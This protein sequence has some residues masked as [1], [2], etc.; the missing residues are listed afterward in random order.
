L[1]IPDSLFNTQ[2]YEELL[3]FVLSEVKYPEE[4]LLKSYDLF[5][6]NKIDQSYIQFNDGRTIERIST[7]LV[8]NG[9]LE[10]TVLSF[11]D[12]TEKVEAEKALIKAKIHA[13]EA[14]RTKSEFLATMSHELR[15]PLNS[16]IG[17]S[18]ILRAQLFGLLNERQLKYL[19]NISISGNHLLNLI[20]D[21]LDI[22]RIESGDVSLYYETMS[23]KELFEDVRNIAIPL[24]SSKNIF[25]EF[26]AKPADLKIYADKIKVKQILHNL[27][28]NALK[29]TPNNGHV[30]VWAKMS[31]DTIEISVKDNGIG[32]PEDKQKIIFEPFKQLDSSLSRNYSGT[33]LGLMIVKK[34]IEMHGGEIRVESELTKGSKFTIILPIKK[35]KE[36]KKER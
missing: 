24:A 25:L 33:G 1:K 2:I 26:S 27:V 36:L 16:V 12:V 34:F 23:V 15:T 28:T 9:I 21:I 29:F 5:R 10:G 7:P 31:A 35:K 30:N 11:R 18:D 17:F 14:N 13:E 8:I 4:Y 19:N 6:S 20:N 32:I 22:S 3:N